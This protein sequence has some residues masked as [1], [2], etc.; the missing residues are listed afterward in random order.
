MIGKNLRANASY[1]IQAPTKV[2]YL[3]L[4]VLV[5][6]LYVVGFVLS[7]SLSL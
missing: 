5:V 1:P 6:A 2:A 3:V 7:S 4:A